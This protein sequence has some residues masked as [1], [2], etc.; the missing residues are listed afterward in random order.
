MN[1]GEHESSKDILANFNNFFS[2]LS[3]AF[4]T[5]DAC[6]IYRE[7]A[8]ETKDAEEAIE[9]MKKSVK[10]GRKYITEKILEENIGRL[11]TVKDARAFMKCKKDLAK[12]Y[13]E[14]G[15][16][17]LS[18]NEYKDLLKLDLEDNLNV[19]Y[20]LVP[21]YIAEKRYEDLYD[22]IEKYSVRESLFDL[23]LKALYYFLKGD[24]INFKR[25]IKKALN[26]N[27]YVAQYMLFIK[28]DM[29]LNN[30]SKEE[31]IGMKF[32]EQMMRSWGQSRQAMNWLV[33]EYFSY[34]NKNKVDTQMKK[35]E[36]KNNLREY[37]DE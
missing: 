9:L 24:N 21:I 11:W 6:E 15:Y 20:E 28:V 19:K 5:R 32:A 35:D 34:C 10:E 30:I 18:I 17:D 1:N 25:F 2:K 31:F 37:F 29:G 7:K 13:K 27:L 36:V 4:S 26:A 23:Y 3:E 16:I 14:N 33:N 12:I 8:L 22:L